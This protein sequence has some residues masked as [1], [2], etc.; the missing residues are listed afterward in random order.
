VEKVERKEAQVPPQPPFDLTS[1]QVEAYRVF[2][3]AP[4]R[5]LELAQS[6]YEASMISYPRTSSQ[7]LP[8]KLNLKRI[9][10]AVSKNPEYAAHAGKLLA[11]NRLAPLEGKKED[12]AHPAIHPTGVVGQ[13]GEKEMRLY[14]LIVKRFLSCFSESARREQMKVEL[15]SGTENYAA[16]GSRTTC[17]GWFEIYAPYAKVDEVQLPPFSEGEQ[18]E[19][20]DFQIEEKKTQPPK[21]YTAASI[22]SE[23]ERLGL[24]TK[25]TRAAIV[26]TLFKRGYV[27]GTSINVTPFGMAV[28]DLLSSVAGEIMDEELT[29]K[30]EEEMELIADG[31]NEQKAIEDGKRVLLGI[32]EK[33]GGKEREIGTGLMAGLRRKEAGDSLLGRCQKC[34][35]ELRSI[36]SKAGKQFA[37]CTGYPD[38]GATFPLPQQAKIVPVGRACEKCGTPVV[39]VLRKGRNTFEMCLD[40]ACETKRGWGNY[41]RS[42]QGAAQK[43]SA[44]AAA[45]KK[46]ASSAGAQPAQ[47]AAQKPAEAAGGSMAQ[48][49][50]QA[51]A[52]SQ[53]PASGAPLAG[54]HAATPAQALAQKQ[55]QGAPQ[56]EAQ[57][58]LAEALPEPAQSFLQPA[59][60]EPVGRDA[61]KQSQV[62]SRLAAF[63]KPKRKPAAKKPAKRTGGKK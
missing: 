62:A 46:P 55:A 44:A 7:K 58:P 11:Q 47:A 18:V 32:L 21:R 14:D 10:E 27:E 9:I 38:C 43:K 41:G 40:P 16:S 57:K 26:E 13:A 52:A 30:I 19:V 51:P 36:Q 28:Y 1:L 6:L 37:G 12:P 17:P 60:Q 24:G 50:A 61:R 22:I 23:L 56:R 33:F 29:H 3:F 8:A 34:G 59:A 20:A 25:A 5:T 54:A 42:A 31:E 39:K 15:L 49:P 48:P 2:N 53:K 4:A 45:A 63:P 35:G